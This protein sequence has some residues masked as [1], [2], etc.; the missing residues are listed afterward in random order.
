MQEAD[1]I[2]SRLISESSNSFQW[3]GASQAV[4]LSS[5]TPLTAVADSGQGILAKEMAPKYWLPPGVLYSFPH[6]SGRQEKWLLCSRQGCHVLHPQSQSQEATSFRVGLQSAQPLHLISVCHP[7]S[8]HSSHQENKSTLILPLKTM[9]SHLVPQN[10]VI[11]SA[12]PLP[13][14]SLFLNRCRNTQ[15]GGKKE[16]SIRCIVTMIAS[17]LYNKHSPFLFCRGQQNAQLADW[18]GLNKR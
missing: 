16:H 11:G 12:W 13:H 18:R 17:F 8:P 4:C 1:S 14:P 6:F 9:V 15:G 2:I 10:S 5:K 3:F 7:F